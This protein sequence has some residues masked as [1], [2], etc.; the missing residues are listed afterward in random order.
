MVHR[1]R[2]LININELFVEF[3][4]CLLTK[5]IIMWKGIIIIFQLGAILPKLRSNK[6]KLDT[7]QKFSNVNNLFNQYNILSF[8]GKL[9]KTIVVFLQ[10]QG[11]FLK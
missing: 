9:I 6:M 1:F 4:F 10:K 8:F 11:H 2:I 7:A 3:L 5:H